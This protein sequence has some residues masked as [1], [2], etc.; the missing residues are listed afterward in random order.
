MRGIA[1]SAAWW[2]G[3]VVNAL[4]SFYE[5]AIHR[6]RLLLGW[7]TVCWQINHLGMYNVPNQ[8][9][10]LS[11]PSLREKAYWPFWLGLGGANS[12]VPVGRTGYY[13]IMRDPIQQVTVRSSA[14]QY[15]PT[16]LNSTVESRRRCEPTRQQSWPSLQF[17]RRWG[18]KLATI[19]WWIKIRLSYDV[20][21]EKVISIDQNS[22]SQ[23]AVESVVLTLNFDLHLSKVNDDIWHQRC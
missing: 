18:I 21:V 22:R 3:V 19:Q 17:L 2:R 9:G 6:A 11:L 23:C 8:L 1:N 7:V 14:A 20:I 12:L 16:R 13:Y 4:A 15:T 5:V 10:Q